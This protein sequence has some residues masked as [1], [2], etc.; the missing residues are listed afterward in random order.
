MTL[1]KQDKDNLKTALFFLREYKNKEVLGDADN[2]TGID[3]KISHTLHNLKEADEKA[4]QEIADEL[5]DLIKD[6]PKIKKIIKEK[7]F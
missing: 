6:H 2:I 5:F 3:I 4:L 1:N 7:Y